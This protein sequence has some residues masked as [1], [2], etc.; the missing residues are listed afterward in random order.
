MSWIAIRNFEIEKTERGFVVL[1]Y[2]KSTES[3]EVLSEWEQLDVAICAMLD[4]LKGDI[5]ES[6]S[7]VTELSPSVYQEQKAFFNA[8]RYRAK[9]TF[10]L[11]VRKEK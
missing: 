9:A 8:K 2:E 1:R 6:L 7:K 11:S 10:A 5:Y 4:E 3:F